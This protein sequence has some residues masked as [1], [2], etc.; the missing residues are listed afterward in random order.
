M[1]EPPSIYLFHALASETSTPSR[2]KL[3]QGVPAAAATG[4]E[5]IA[6][7]VG[8]FNFHHQKVAHH[9]LQ[10]VSF[11]LG[12]KGSTIQ[13]LASFFSVAYALLAGLLGR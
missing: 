6:N 4:R 2:R 8:C 11:I 10:Y 12:K 13:G 7:H 5:R 3:Q 1:S 9:Y